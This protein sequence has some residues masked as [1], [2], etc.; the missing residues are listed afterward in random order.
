MNLHIKAA[1]LVRSLRSAYVTTGDA[2]A[3]M[4][5]KKFIREVTF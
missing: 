5:F 3:F 1:S 4:D 2:P